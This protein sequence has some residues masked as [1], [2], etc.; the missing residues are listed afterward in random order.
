MVL[1]EAW[2][3]EEGGRKVGSDNRATDGPEK[4]HRG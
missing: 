4:A 3:A 1:E 2:E